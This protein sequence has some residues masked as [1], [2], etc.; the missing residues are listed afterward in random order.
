MTPRAFVLFGV[1]MAVWAVCLAP[2]A[3][4]GPT[5]AEKAAALLSPV[6]ARVSS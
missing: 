6:A 2:A 4:V 1:W 5:Q 3:A